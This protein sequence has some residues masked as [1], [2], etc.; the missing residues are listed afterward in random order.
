MSQG[1]WWSPGNDISCFHLHLEATPKHKPLAPLIR[2]LITLSPTNRSTR[3]VAVGCRPS[4][5]YRNSITNGLACNSPAT[6][7]WP[8]GR[9]DAQSPRRELSPRPAYSGNNMQMLGKYHIEEALLIFDMPW[10]IGG[11][12][13]VA[14]RDRG[15]VIYLIKHL[16]SLLLKIR[17][18][19]TGVRK[20]FH[21]C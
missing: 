17:R 1:P 10:H 9:P 2:L 18:K 16:G 7:H 4:R 21:A 5:R 6:R 8:H 20:G 19:S 3:A 15:G 14:S 13:R 11:S 12:I